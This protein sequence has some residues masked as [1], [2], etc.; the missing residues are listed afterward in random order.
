MTKLR[1]TILFVGA[2][3]LALL[4]VLTLMGA[5]LLVRPVRSLTGVARRMASGDLDQP[6]KV[7]EGGEI[8]VLGE[9]I[10]TMRVQLKA[11][12]EQI[13]RWSE[14][15][16]SK[17]SQRTGELTTRNQQLAAVTAVATAANEIRDQKGMLS[18]CLKVVLEQTG[19]E[20]AAIRLVDGNGGQLAVASAQGD[21]SGFPCSKRAVGLD[22]CPCGYVASNDIP[23]YLGPEER[24]TFQPPCR[25]PQGRDVMIVPLSS[26]KGIL[27]VLSLSRSQG[28][29]PGPE[30]RE[31]LEAIGN[32]I[33]IAIENTRLLGELGRVE[34]QRELDRMKAEFISAISHELRTP[35]GFIKGYA[36][37]LLRD[38]IPIDPD[39]RRE[40]LHVIDEES[41][42]LQRMIDDLFDASRL[43]ARRL[44]MSLS[45]VSLRELLANALHKLAPRLKHAGHALETHLPLNDTTVIADAGRIEQVL[46]N[47]LDNATRYSD[48]G[49]GIEVEAVIQ[50]RYVLVSVKDH[51][52]GI[53][54]QEQERIFEPFYRGA[55]SR[56]RGA[57]GTGLGLPIS[58]GIIA[59][60]GGELWVE[61]IP[62]VGSTFMFTLP[63]EVSHD[64]ETSGQ[65]HRLGVAPK[66]EV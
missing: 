58:R 57:G 46:H 20:T 54:A 59:S 51:G 53:P 39:T 60:H 16:E 5:W 31:T 9:S 11:S 23:L 65:G 63:L 32:Q 29:P 41:N 38:D 17:V 22:E 66:E 34:A 15:L 8:S 27:G 12:M 7:G 52:D 45:P 55:N 10:E 26:P 37:T 18:R 30:E 25:A 33:A 1:N 40:F 47:L 6:V 21:F 56:R 13:K 28:D 2:L 24:K 35:L 50:D 49:S 36:T 61:S 43:Q 42:K 64:T 4:W 14:E 3:S 19:A 48:S 62:G 44:Q